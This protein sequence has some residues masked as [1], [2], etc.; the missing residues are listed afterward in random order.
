[1]I[2]DN[3]TK[4]TRHSF[5]GVV[6]PEGEGLYEVR[7]RRTTTPSTRSA[8]SD[9]LGPVRPAQPGS[10]GAART[11]RSGPGAQVVTVVGAVGVE[12]GV[13]AA[14][15]EVDDQSDDEPHAETHPG[16]PVQLQDEEERGQHAEGGHHG[17]PGPLCE[18]VGGA[19]HRVWTGRCLCR[20]IGSG[21]DAV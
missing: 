14:V 13:P 19:L 10:A 7:I 12:H 3:R 17:H 20:R 8:C 18:W 2:T 16:L 5:E 11:G 4:P 1:M 15:G 9:P 21:S 6:F